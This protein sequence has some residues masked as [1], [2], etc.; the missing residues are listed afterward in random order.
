M[1]NLTLHIADIIKDFLTD[2]YKG[3]VINHEQIVK[4]ANTIIDEIHECD[5]EAWEARN[6]R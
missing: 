3:G 5:K 2:E 4:F 6:E 1:R